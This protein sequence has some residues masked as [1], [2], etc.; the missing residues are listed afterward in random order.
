ML[1]LCKQHANLEFV[2]AKLLKLHVLQT[3]SLEH[4]A[5]ACSC[6][7]KSK[8]CMYGTCEVCQ[9]EKVDFL[10]GE[11]ENEATSFW[12]WVTVNKDK[13]NKDGEKLVSEMTKR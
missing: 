4:L 8:E 9:H 6:L 2:V 13:V 1:N 12:Q 11:N 5:D 7:P 10:L 3:R